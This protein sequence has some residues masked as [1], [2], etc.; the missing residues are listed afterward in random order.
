MLEGAVQDEGWGWIQEA[1]KPG[2]E[3][4]K[5]QP[6]FI[7]LDESIVEEETARLGK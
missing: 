3:L 5:H 7:K 4:P 1:M 2:V 6:L